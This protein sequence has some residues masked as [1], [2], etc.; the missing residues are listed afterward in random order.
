[1]K[2]EFQGYAIKIINESYF[3]LDSVEHVLSYDKIYSCEGENQYAVKHGVRV[4]RNGEQVSSALLCGYGGATGVYSHSYV[5]VDSDFFI[6]CSD[7]VF[8]LK[9]PDLSLNWCKQLDDATCFE[10]YSFHDGL[11]IHGEL[12][13]S[14]V[15]IHGNLVWHFTGR[16]IFVTPDGIDDFLIRNNDRIELKD[17][18]G[19]QYILNA[20]GEVIGSG[21]SLIR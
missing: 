2:I 18:Q 8:S 16:D 7:R 3:N 17:W 4:T 21:S 5:I 19:N 20:D 11:I 1:M 10:I 9:L 15:D 12:A 14:R 6:C 13:I